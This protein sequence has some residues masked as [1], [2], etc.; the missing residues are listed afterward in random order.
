[1]PLVLTDVNS[2]ILTDSQ[3]SFIGGQFSNA[4]PLQL[5][6]TTCAL[7]EDVETSATGQAASRRGTALLGGDVGAS[8]VI[9]VLD[10]YKSPGAADYAVAMLT[11]G[12][13]YKLN[14]GVWT[15][16]SAGSP[17]AGVVTSAT[18][19]SFLYAGNGTNIAKW[20]NATWTT[21]STDT[22][23]ST[24]TILLWDGFR[25]IASGV[26]S[27]PDAIYFSGQINDALWASLP[28]GYQIQVG[29]GDGAAITAVLPWSGTNLAVFKRNQVWMI[30]AD[31]QLNVSDMPVQRVHRRIGC[32][33]TNSATQ[34]G[35]D[36]FF[37]ASDLKVRSLQ[38]TIASDNQYE[39]GIPLSFPVQ[40]I[41]DRINPSTASKAAGV[42]W[43]GQYLLAT[44]LDSSSTNNYILVYNTLTG[45]WSGGWTNLP[46]S[47]FA[48]RN[49][50]GVDKLIM[51]LANDNAVIEFLDY[52]AES[53]ATDAT[54]T[55]YNGFIPFHFI[56]RGMIFGDLDSPK[57]G[58]NVNMKLYKSKGK[59][60]LTAIFDEGELVI[61]KII[62][63][64]DPTGLLFPITFPAV[65]PRTGVQPAS[66]SLM[67]YPKFHQVQFEVKSVTAGRKEIRQLTAQAFP[68]AIDLRGKFVAE[69]A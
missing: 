10:Y 55:D 5:D 36:V 69:S 19:N 31:P 40:D 47:Y 35:A 27:A 67:P 6:E 13:T 37:L 51:G 41:T 52:V 21:L 49:D 22:P 56:T 63:T 38:Q 24:A 62:D 17:L 4:V 61:T 44:A 30:G 66:M 43:K 20:D 16:L 68:E 12:G 50:N 3:S 11:G 42:F 45:K 64:G 15:L 57:K 26:A 34:C 65:F 59:I 32:V 23:P 54:Y 48:V 39:L 18:G 25:L 46:I 1:M 28:G 58:L 9:S 7:L 8:G 29:G 14:G 33:A 53:N 60:S 2:P